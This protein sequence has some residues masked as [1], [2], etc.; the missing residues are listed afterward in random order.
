MINLTGKVAVVTGAAT[1]IGRGVATFLAAQGMKVAVVYHRS[2]PEETMRDI[3]A[4]DGTAI[5]VSAD[6]GDRLSIRRLFEETAKAFGPRIDVLVNNAA[7][8]TNKWLLE[9]NEQDYELLMC[10]N[11][12]GYFRCIQEVLPY[13]K[14]SEHGRIINVASIHAKRPTAFDPVYGM[15][16]GAI[17][18]LTREAALALGQY[19]I[20]ANALNLGAVRVSSKSGNYPWKR[21]IK[22]WQS[23]KRPKGGYLC[24]RMGL[25]ED[26]GYLVAFLCA[27]ESQ[28][29][30]GSSL[31]AD[32]G[33]QMV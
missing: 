17:K 21:P 4:V 18:M 12:M 16:K 15:T 8:Q 22:S 20:T 5:A 26:V 24:G 19:G 30:T 6:C 1:G 29:I 14:R 7:M 33:A 9:Y 32:G 2:P 25:P 11:V 28:Y 3:E 31:R 10:T 13:M 27:D 23:D